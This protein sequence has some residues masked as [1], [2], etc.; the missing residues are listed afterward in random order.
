[1]SSGA[2]KWLK[3]IILTSQNLE[4]LLQNRCCLQCYAA[5]FAEMACFFANSSNDWKQQLA[6]GVLKIGCVKRETIHKK[7]PAC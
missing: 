7:K 3:I 6:K 4:T 5:R 1:M 2:P